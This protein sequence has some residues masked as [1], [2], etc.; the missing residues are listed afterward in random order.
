MRETGVASTADHA[1][2]N[3]ADSATRRRQEKRRKPTRVARDSPYAP[4]PEQQ[5]QRNEDR[6][7]PHGQ[8]Y[9]VGE[10]RRGQH[11][12][13]R[14]ESL[15]KRARARGVGHWQVT[16]SCVRTVGV[17]TGVLSSSIFVGASESATNS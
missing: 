9:Q 6:V 11:V 2:E 17:T 3:R 13:R 10:D 8:D 1:D 4:H 15:Q 14:V 12:R 7:V 5:E 16:A